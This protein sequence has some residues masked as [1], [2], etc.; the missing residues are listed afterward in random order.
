M[1]TIEVRVRK[2]V[3]D[4]GGPGMQGSNRDPRMTS[5]RRQ[6]HQKLFSYDIATKP[7]LEDVWTDF[8]SILD[9]FVSSCSRIRRIDEMVIPQLKL[10]RNTLMQFDKLKQP[11]LLHF[12][13]LTSTILESM[14]SQ[15]EQRLNSFNQYTPLL[16]LTFDQLLL[17]LKIK[18]YAEQNSGADDDLGHQHHDDEDESE[19]YEDVEITE[20][21]YQ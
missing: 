16:D 21:I 7:S 18:T 14:R 1:I 20:A 10:K 3:L 11:K 9:M 12:S 15:P 4:K 19:A 8:S 2:N 13:K 6:G 17:D 5:G